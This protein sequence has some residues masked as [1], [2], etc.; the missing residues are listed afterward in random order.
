VV[1]G[2]GNTL[3]APYAQARHILPQLGE[4]LL[5][6]EAREIVGSVGNELAPRKPNEE[7]VV[8][9]LDPR[10]VVGRT[11]CGKGGDRRPKGAR[12]ARKRGGRLQARGRW[13]S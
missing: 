11:R 6:Q 4:R 1:L 8:L 7:V 10:P 13:R 5:M 2:L 9:A 3:F 12:I